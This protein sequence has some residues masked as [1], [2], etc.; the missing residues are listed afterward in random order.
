MAAAPNQV[1]LSET[2]AVVYGGMMPTRSSRQFRKR[3]VVRK[4]RHTQDY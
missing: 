1:P 4:C 2:I 3:T